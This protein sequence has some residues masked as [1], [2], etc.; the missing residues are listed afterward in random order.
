MNQKWVTCWSKAQ[1]GMGLVAHL[2]QPHQEVQVKIPKASAC[3]LRFAFAYDDHEVMVDH[4]NIQAGNKQYKVCFHKKSSITIFP[5]QSILSDE[6]IFEDTV[7]EC[8]ISYDLISDPIVSSGVAIYPYD[9]MKTDNDVLYGLC[10]IDILTANIKGA[11]RVIGDSITEQG[12]W[13][14]PLKAWL[15]NQGYVLLNHGISGNRLLHEL[16]HIHIDATH[17]YILEGTTKEGNKG[18]FQNIDVM[19]QCFGIAGVKRIQEQVIKQDQGI[20]IQLFAL[21]TNDLYQPGT[22]CADIDELPTLE[23]YTKALDQSIQALKMQAD[24]ILL[25]AIPPF[26]HADQVDEK[27]ETLRNSINQAYQ[28]LSNITNVILFDDVLCD[29]TRAW[30]KGYHQ[31]DHLHPSKS[32]GNEMAK[33][34]EEVLKQWLCGS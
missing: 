29:D 11:I 23:E 27:K 4:V 9:E 25:L 31:G 7:T 15:R 26:L 30:K 22:F 34:I 3:K 1:R 24:H 6:V 2:Y 17:T 8:M 21:G 16:K 5:M 28:K 14:T 20:A 10:G 32:G 33:R 18:M 13:T 19:N 12:N